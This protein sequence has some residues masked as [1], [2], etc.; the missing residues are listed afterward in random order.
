MPAGLR[1]I[2]EKEMAMPV[3]P[4]FD[5]I[6]DNYD[7]WYDAP[8]GKRLFQEEIDCLRCLEY[9]FSDRWLEVGVGTGR[10]AKALGCKF[11]IDLSLPMATR[12]ARR[13]VWVF[14]GRGEQLP[15]P[16]HVFDGVLMAFTLCFLNRP[17]K[18]LQECARVMRPDGQLLVGTIPADSTWGRSYLRKGAEG[19][20][21]YARARFST[22]VETMQL[23]GNSGFV[24]Q[25]ACS[26]LFGGPNIPSTGTPRVKS[27]IVADAGFIGLLF[28][29]RPACL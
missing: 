5:T 22:I 16:N 13:G 24:L 25:R 20:P 18:V 7:R 1:A 9:D 29:I 11:G 23:L 8:E 21:L 12:A 27:G 14:V 6:A 19:H 17:E 15:F 3:Q 26:A 4:V 28:G 10:F 2:I